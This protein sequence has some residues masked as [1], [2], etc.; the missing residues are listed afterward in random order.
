MVRDITAIELFSG[1]GGFS[2]GMKAAGFKIVLA[3][4]IWKPAADVYRRNNP[5]T[6]YIEGDI[7]EKRDEIVSRSSGTPINV[8]FGGFPCQSY[9]MAGLRDP[10]DPRGYLYK[11]FLYIV[12]KVK[13]NFFI[14]ENVKGMASVFHPREDLSDEMLVKF[15]SVSEK[16]GRLKF[17]KRVAVQRELDGDEKNEMTSIEKVSTKLSAL[18]M[19]M[20]EPILPKIEREASR[21]G[22]HVRFKILNAARFGVPQFRQRM[23]IIGSRTPIG[24]SVFPRETHASRKTISMGVARTGSLISG[25]TSIP[26][27]TASDSISDLESME[28]DKRFFHVFTSHSEKFLERIKA[29]KCGES[30]LGYR[31]SYYRIFPDRPS[32]VVLQNH[33]GVFVHYKKDRLLTPRELARLQSFRDDFAFFGTKSNVLAMIGNAVPPILASS[34]GGS[35]VRF[36]SDQDES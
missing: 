35:I 26:Y 27:K 1:C 4:D 22:Y 8:V 25:F 30:A 19:S 2:E 17:L 18:Q 31:E 7:I 33:G 28:E 24:D 10:T 3:N 12:D 11:Q 14:G 32:P 16:L 23:I 34:V 20:M 21:I 6:K 36:F 13:P 9:S 29:M 15:K 5:G